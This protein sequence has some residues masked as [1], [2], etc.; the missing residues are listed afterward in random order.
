MWL[1]K[2]IRVDRDRKGALF[3]LSS[4]HHGW[5]GTYRDTCPIMISKGKGEAGSQNQACLLACL[6]EFVWEDCRIGGI[7][8]WDLGLQILQ[9]GRVI[10]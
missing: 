4:Q 8:I 1:W 2:H 6:H 9:R 3:S 10:G 5:K 7:G